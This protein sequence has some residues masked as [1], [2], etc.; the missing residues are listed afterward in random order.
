M[1]N[2]NLLP[3]REEESLYQKIRLKKILMMV[4]VAAALVNM[5]LHIIFSQQE[6]KIQERINSINDEIKNVNH[7]IVV[8]HGYGIY[9]KNVIVRNEETVLHELLTW[10]RKQENIRAIVMTSSR[11]NPDAHPDIFSDYDFCRGN[12]LVQ[13]PIGC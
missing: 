4:V 2:L 3:W 7:N 1:V 6:N 11:A 5:I 9:L 10:G 12:H 8:V 13:G